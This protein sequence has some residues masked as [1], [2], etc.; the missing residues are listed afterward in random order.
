MKNSFMRI[1]YT[2]I[3]LGVCSAFGQSVSGT[4]TEG[5]V[6]IPGVNVV[7][8]GT[9]NGTSSDFDGLYT[10]SGV[11]Q[12][13]ILIFSYIGFQTQEIAYTGQATIDVALAADAEALDQVV[14]LAYGQ[15]QN[16]KTVTTA[17]A[18]VDTDVIKELPISQAEAAL[19]GTVPGVVV[20]QNS[21]SPGSPQT[22]RVRGVGTP[23]G[24]G[25]LYIVDGVQVP[26]LTFL[27]P[28]DIVSQTVLKDAASSAIYGSRGGNGVILV[29]TLSGKRSNKK[30]EINI[31]GYYGIQTLANKPD[32]MNRD[33]YVEYYNQGVAAANGNLATNFR[34]AFSEEERQALPDTDWYDVLFNDEPIQD[35]YASLT[36]GTEK[37]SYAVSGGFFNQVG[38]LGGEDKAEFDRRNIRGAFDV[39]ITDNITFN[40]IGQYQKQGRFNISQNNGGA[41]VAISSFINALPAI[42][43]AY[44]AQGNFF[45]PGLQGSRPVANGVT[46]NSLGAVQ[47]PLF[48]L[49]LSNSQTEQTITNVSTSLQWEPVENLKL[50]ASYGAFEGRV[51]NRTFQPSV[52][53]PA[54][55]YDT[56]A[57][58]FYQEVSNDVVN[59]QYGGTAEYFFGKLSEQDHNLNVL[60]GYEVVETTFEG[61]AAVNDPGNFL[62]N[63]FESVNFSLSEDFSD[64]VITPGITAEI[65]LV[66]YFGKLDYNYKE[67]YLFSTVVRN[68]RSSNFGPDNRSGWFPA[69]SAGWVVSEED[70]LQDS[71]VINLFKV[72]GS[73]GVSGNDGSPRAL[74]YLSSVNTST[75]Y[76]NLRGIA[77]TGL[78]N[79]NLKWEELTQLNI[80]LDINAL[81]NRLGITLDY[82]VKETSDILLQATTPLSSGINP[83]VENTGDIENRGV[84]A[85]VSW[86][87]TY[88][89][90]FSWN[91]SA[92]VGFNENEVTS[93]GETSFIDSAQISPQFGSAFASRTQVGDPIA[94][95]FGFVVDGVDAAGNLIFKD[96]DGSGNNPLTPDAGDR[97]IIG[98]PNPDVTFGLNLGFDYKGFDFSAFMSGTAGNDIFDATI[99]YDAAATNR[100]ASYIEESGAPRNVSAS[101]GTNGEH[102]ISDFHVKDGS[103]MKLK[104][105]TLGYTIPEAASKSIGA[106]SVRVY[107][108]GQNLFFLT[109]YSGLDPEIGQNNLNSPLN[110]GIDQ[111]FFPQSRNFLLGFN[112]NF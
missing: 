55:E 74:A 94:S 33:Q 37:L 56:S 19:Q 22:V 79:P 40:V 38:I 89:N 47:N 72:R 77:L 6:P 30:P 10:I 28:N 7:V 92:N 93:L 107:L 23:N 83:S 17:L 91:I 5:G 8:K 60:A 16:K 84:E 54:Q 36:G 104:N 34:G 80:G 96:L 100:P 27:N 53:Q 51:F 71:A 112:F 25:P 57:N 95:F 50:K 69:F 97:A 75:S 46:L 82:Y 64:A 52:F 35:I 106:S 18:T 39:D 62:V 20:Q 68:D 85:I 61:G 78:S 15:V 65:G 2:I 101:G 73:W 70:F 49:E 103:Y 59:R 12:G 4:I 63:D 26:N 41:G 109:K 66:S 13:D 14:V 87:E 88:K 90:G 44:D 43:P 24:S 31:R 58:V 105:V 3:F 1:L 110:I 67:K 81:D 98:D 76:G 111:G 32:L 42:Y 29:E 21:G 45:N 102:L 11:N 99:R 9:A 108:S 48:A 86:K